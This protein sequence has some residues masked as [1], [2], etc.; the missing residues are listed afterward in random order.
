M[1]TLLIRQILHTIL[2]NIPKQLVPQL[3]NLIYKKMIRLKYR[4]KEN[5][6]LLLAIRY[7]YTYNVR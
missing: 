6:F 3:M 4:L 1:N 5:S 7:K 2:Y